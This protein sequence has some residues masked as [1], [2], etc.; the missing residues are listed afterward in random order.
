MFLPNLFGPLNSEN[1]G[2]NYQFCAEYF[3]LLENENLANQFLRSLPSEVD[4]AA[5]SYRLGY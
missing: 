3:R 1:W 2:E 5:F 4:A